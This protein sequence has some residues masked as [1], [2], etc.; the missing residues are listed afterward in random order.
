MPIGY[1]ALRRHQVVGSNWADEIQSLAWALEGV[2]G[3]NWVDLGL[4]DVG[5]LD[6]GLLGAASSRLDRQ[7]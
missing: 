6:V 1:W 3:E 2:R 5:L 7:S 4:L